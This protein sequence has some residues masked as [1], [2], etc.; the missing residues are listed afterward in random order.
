[1]KFYLAN[2]VIMKLYFLFLLL[3]EMVE[4]HQQKRETG[5]GR[6]SA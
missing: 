5:E 4:R 2:P 3:R 6:K 1:M